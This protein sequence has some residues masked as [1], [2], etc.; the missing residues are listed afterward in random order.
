LARQPFVSGSEIFWGDRLE[1][2]AL[3]DAGA[4]PRSASGTNQNSAATPRKR[5]ASAELAED[6]RTKTSSS[7]E[8]RSMVSADAEVVANCAL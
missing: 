8:G 4:W 3:D 7:T 6:F 2:D 1:N 5:H